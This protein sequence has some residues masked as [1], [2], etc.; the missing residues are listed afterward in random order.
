MFSCG[1]GAFLVCGLADAGVKQRDQ[2]MLTFE[3]ASVLGINGIIEKLTVRYMKPR[4]VDIQAGTP[5]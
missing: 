5:R 2:S 1:L 4:R 3:S